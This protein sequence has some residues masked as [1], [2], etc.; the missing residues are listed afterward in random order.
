MTTSRISSIPNLTAAV[1]KPGGWSFA[2]GGDMGHE[3]VLNP[4]PFPE[5]LRTLNRPGEIEVRA[6]SRQMFIEVWN[7]AQERPD[8]FMGMFF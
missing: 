1:W 3:E 6:I 2:Y 7:Q 4:V 8:G 5:D